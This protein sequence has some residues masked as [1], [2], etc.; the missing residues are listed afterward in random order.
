MCNTP[1]YPGHCLLQLS[2]TRG[3]S[4]VNTNINVAGSHGDRP[5]V[6]HAKLRLV[7][8]L[9]APIRI[10][11]RSRLRSPA[12]VNMRTRPTS[13]SSTVQ[14]CSTFPQALL[15]FRYGLHATAGIIVR[16]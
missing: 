11:K 12:R 7:F 16:R 10:H 8:D 14:R 6:S 5:N 4:S 3:M 2:N 13:F 15:S 9:R 1:T